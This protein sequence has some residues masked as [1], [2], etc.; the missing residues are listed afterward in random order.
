MSAERQDGWTRVA[1]YALIN[2]DE[3][4]ILLVRIAPG[5]PDTGDWTLPGGGLNFGEDPADAV[6]RELDEETG[7][8]GRIE[9]LAFVHSATGSESTRGGPWHAIRIVYHMAITGG[10]LRDEQD[11]STDKAAW[12]PI[13]Q[14]RELPLVDLAEFAVNFVH[15]PDRAV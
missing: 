12:I 7:L 8:Q 1:A 13:A 15:D 4:R 5:Y 10:T 14:A 6:I 2:D 9:S 11:E 3:G